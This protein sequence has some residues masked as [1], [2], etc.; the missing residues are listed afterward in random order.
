MYQ[1][2]NE[3]NSFNEP[4]CSRDTQPL[5]VA[6]NEQTS[7]LQLD[8]FAIVQPPQS[9]QAKVKKNGLHWF[10]R[11]L[12][13]H[14]NPAL[15]KLIQGADT[16]RCIYILDPWFAASQGSINKWRYNYYF[17]LLLTNIYL[18]VVNTKVVYPPTPPPTLNWCLL[19]C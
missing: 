8:S 9:Q 10:R 3:V 7:Q 16:F 19:S 6:T 5:P 13:L 11:C 18:V 4:S 15:I 17:L 14:D 2:F 1:P 12:R